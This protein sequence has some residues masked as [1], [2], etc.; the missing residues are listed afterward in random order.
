VL[1][2]STLH[3]RNATRVIRILRDELAIPQ[4]R[5]RLL[6]NRYAK[7]ALLQLDDISRA[8][9]M[10]VTAT[11]PNHYQRALESSDTG[12]P[13]YEGARG[14]AITTS[15][16]DMAAQMTGAK[17]ERPGLLRRALPSFLRN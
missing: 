15:L 4:Q 12:V 13:L 14:A 2:Q 11:I 9:N 3:V 6:V 16:I 10:E 1:Q 8:L 7:N 17:I 5:L